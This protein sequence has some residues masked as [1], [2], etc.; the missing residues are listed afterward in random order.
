MARN[1]L[2]LIFVAL[3]LAGGIAIGFAS[4]PGPWYASLPKPPFNPPNWIFAPVW[5]VLYILVGIAGARTFARDRRAAAM[6]VW[7]VQLV[8]NFCWSPAFFVLHDVPAALVVVL[9][10]LV[11]ILFFIGLSWRRD[12]LSALLFVPYALWVAFASL[13]NASILYLMAA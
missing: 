7:F 6:R 11:A 1:R 12:R 9:A 13:L 2:L 3:T 4:Q 10:L 5:T 8:L